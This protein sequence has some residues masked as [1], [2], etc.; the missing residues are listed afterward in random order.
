MQNEGARHASFALPSM[1]TPGRRFRIGPAIVLF[2]ALYCV[3]VW[4]F[5]EYSSEWG[6]VI[7]NWWDEYHDD[8]GQPVGSMAF[9]GSTGELFLYVARPW[10]VLVY[11]A[12]FVAAMMSLLYAMKE[13]SNGA[14]AVYVA[15]I[16]AMLA[17]QVRFVYLGVFTCVWRSL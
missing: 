9:R 5:T 15:V 3:T 1:D 17:I 10:G 16:V 11:P 4:Y 7:R 14:R 6:A 2:L 8:R 13:P 12:S